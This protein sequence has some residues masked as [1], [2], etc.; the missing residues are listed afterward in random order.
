MQILDDVRGLSNVDGSEGLIFP[1]NLRRL[2]FGEHGTCPG[3][4]GD[5][6]LKYVSL[7]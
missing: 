1:L 5:M 7:P 4:G 3:P 6:I 2:M